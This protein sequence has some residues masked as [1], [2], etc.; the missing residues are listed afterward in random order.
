MAREPGGRYLQRREY[1]WPG[2]G[3]ELAKWRSGPATQGL[4]HQKNHLVFVTLSGTTAHTKA[5]IEGGERYVGADFPGAVS[6]IPAGR[7][8]EATHGSG[9]LDYVTIHLA[10]RP[11]ADYVGF[12]NQ[13]DPLI[14]QLAIALRE[15]AR[16][17]WVS[18]R[19]FVEAVA[20]TL[21]LHLL[22]HYSDRAPRIPSRP[23][24]LTGTR[25]RTVVDY[26]AAHLN[27]DLRVDALA[28]VAG[29]D[30]FHFS[31]AFKQATGLPPHRYVIERRVAHAAELLT[32]SDLTIAEIA[33]HVGLSSQS[34]LTTLFR[35]VTGDTPHAYRTR[36]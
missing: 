28:G 6:F 4:C 13:P 18:G 36:H 7:R 23:A 5:R 14:R 31:R 16:G 1:H 11:D 26:I 2:L 25:L 8:R 30:R 24:G 19:M 29:M 12:T 32:R 15:E 35:K 22:R 10:A 27:D 17:G 34:H 9:E 3:L 21:S 33:H 20:M